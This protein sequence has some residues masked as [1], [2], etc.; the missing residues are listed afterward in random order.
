MT[1]YRE[2]LWPI[3]PCKWPM[4]FSKISKFY[5]MTYL[6][7]TEEWS[8]PRKKPLVGRKNTEWPWTHSTWQIIPKKWP[9]YDSLLVPFGL[10]GSASTDFDLPCFFKRDVYFHCRPSIVARI[11]HLTSQKAPEQL[12]AGHSAL[13]NF[14]QLIS[15]RDMKNLGTVPSRTEIFSDESLLSFRSSDSH[16]SH[17]GR[18]HLYLQPCSETTVSFWNTWYIWKIFLSTP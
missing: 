10:F 3:W 5:R 11:E 18:I 17:S 2:N 12:S 16:F 4:R 6:N 7:K 8:F 9:I 13:I 1:V 14:N 15:D